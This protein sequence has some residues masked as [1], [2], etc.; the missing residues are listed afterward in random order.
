MLLKQRPDYSSL[1]V[2]GCACWTNLRPYNARKLAFHST[3]CAFIGYSPLHKR[4]KC[5]EPKSGRVYISRDVVF[6]EQIFHFKDLH[7]NMRAKLRQEI[8]LLPPDLVP[9]YDMFQVEQNSVQRGENILPDEESPGETQNGAQSRPIVPINSAGDLDPIIG[10]EIQEDL[11]RPA[12]TTWDSDPTA[13][14]TRDLPARTNHALQGQV[15]SSAGATLTV[16]G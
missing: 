15:S 1:K 2:F 4:Y 14:V 8:S 10:T 6:D 7:E 16:E 12:A 3:K 9:S 11:H 5:L 13:M